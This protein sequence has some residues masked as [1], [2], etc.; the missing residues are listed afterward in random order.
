MTRKLGI[1]TDCLNGK[2]DEIS[3]LELAF[4]SG[5]EAF[6]TSQTELAAVSELKTRSEGLGMEF[7]FLH[8]PFM[9]INHMWLEGDSYREVY[10]GIIESIDSASACDVPAVIVHVS[11]GWHPPA[12]NDIGLS[13]Y[14]AIVEHAANKGVIVAFENLRKVGNLTCL[15]DRYEDN[16]HVRFCFDC[17][18]EHCYTKTVGWLDIFTDRLI[19]THIHDNEGRAFDDKTTTRDYHWLPFDG[20]FNYHEMM[21]KLDTYGYSGPLMLEVFRTSRDDYREMTPESFMATCYERIKKISQFNTVNQ[22]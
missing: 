18:H 20:T 7:S 10:N 14:D 2:L 17:G 6:T 12:V 8:S 5:F 11:S 22:A 21:R 4:K 16:P 13:R 15:M 19:A 3:T 9:G 1:N